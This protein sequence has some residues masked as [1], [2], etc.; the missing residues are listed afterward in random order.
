MSKSYGYINEPGKKKRTLSDLSCTTQMYIKHSDGPKLQ[1]DLQAH[2]LKE[3]ERLVSEC[4]S[5]QRAL[6]LKQLEVKCL[7]QGHKSGR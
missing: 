6:L 1:T 3:R 4:E 2:R 5:S 7:A